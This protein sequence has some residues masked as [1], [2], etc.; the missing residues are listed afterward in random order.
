MKQ[1]ITNKN[2][3]AR[4]LLAIGL[5]ILSILLFGALLAPVL[6]HGL[7]GLKSAGLC[8]DPLAR[9]PFRR[10]ADR[11]FMLVAFIGLFPFLRALGLRQRADWGLG[12]VPAKTALRKALTGLTV[13]LFTMMVLVAMEFSLGALG[14]DQRRSFHDLA[15][16]LFSG[17]IS[18]LAVSVL[19]ETFFRGA[20]FAVF[21]RFKGTAAA[22]FGTAFLYATAH[23]IRSHGTFPQVT[24]KS[25]FMVIASGFHGFLSPNQLGAFLAL[26]AVGGFLAFIRL[27]TEHIFYTFG[28]H[29]GWVA[30]I[31]LGRK[32]GNPVPDSPF[33]PLI[34]GYDHI[35]GYLA[36]LYILILWALLYW[37]WRQKEQR[38]ADGDSEA[39]DLLK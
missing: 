39:P 19:E 30:V 8:P 15:H 4:P 18:G 25:G 28:I 13:G 29:A 37:W 17:L 11:A 5:Y 6:N 35:T 14:W 34:S 12:D 24:W 1:Q 10:V 7:Q 27:R 26:F 21:Y 2:D 31:K 32:A 23:F 38:M 36:F 3:A 33:Y 22:L 9:V 20:L 16:A